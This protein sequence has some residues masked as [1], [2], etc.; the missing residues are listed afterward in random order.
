MIHHGG[1]DIDK[2]IRPA[3]RPPTTVS[4]IA[5]L[6]T[7]MMAIMTDRARNEAQLNK[8]NVEMELAVGAGIL[9]LVFTLWGDLH[10]ATNVMSKKFD[11]LIPH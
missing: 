10:N 9:G 7:N 3:F 5:S 8:G 1:Y 11:L 6:T 2:E 4:P